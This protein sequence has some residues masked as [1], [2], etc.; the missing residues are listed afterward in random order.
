MSGFPSTVPSKTGPAIESVCRPSRSSTTGRPVG[1]TE[2]PSL[3]SSSRRQ[4]FAEST[5]RQSR[6][7]ISPRRQ[8]VRA[9]ARIIDAAVDSCSSCSA[10]RRSR[11]SSRYSS[12]ERRRLRFWSAALRIPCAGLVSIIPFSRAYVRIAPSNPSVRVPVPMPPRTIARP[13]F[14]V[15]SVI[16]VLPAATSRIKRVMSADVRSLI[17]RVP[18]KGTMWRLIRPSSV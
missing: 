8:P 10:S 14:L 1:R 5:S 11:P 2:A 3:L 6:L 4:L 7:M 12:S 17:R 16:F 18:S 13:C 9:S 15:F